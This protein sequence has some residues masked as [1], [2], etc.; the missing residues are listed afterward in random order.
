MFYT[1]IE[2]V[3]YNLKVSYCDRVSADKQN[4]LQNL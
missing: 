3:T 1:Y 2:V 4:K